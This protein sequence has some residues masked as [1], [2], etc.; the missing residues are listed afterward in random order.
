MDGEVA[1]T[2][3]RALRREHVHGARAAKGALLVDADT[4]AAAAGLIAPGRARS[5]AHGVVFKPVAEQ[6]WRWAIPR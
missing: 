3:R 5:L 4:G 6:R 2:I 1:A